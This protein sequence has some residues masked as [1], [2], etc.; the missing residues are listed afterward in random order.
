MAG[1][2][3]AQRK[4]AIQGKRRGPRMTWHAALY[5]LGICLL[6]DIILFGVFRYG[7]GK[8]YGILCLL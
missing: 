5:F 3:K 7:F 6:I 4:Q 2:A 8:C 1:A